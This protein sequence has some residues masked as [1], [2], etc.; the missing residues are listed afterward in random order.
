MSP[1][2]PT[3]VAP[4]P[5]RSRIAFPGC[6]LRRE[7]VWRWAILHPTGV[8]RLDEAARALGRSPGVI[9]VALRGLVAAGALTVS[10][11]TYVVR[12]RRI[13][14]I[15]WATFHRPQWVGALA[16]RLSPADI[17]GLMVPDATFTGASAVRLRLGQAPADASEVWV[18]A[19]PDTWRAIERRFADDRWPTA[20]RHLVNVRGLLPDPW[21][22]LDPLPWDQVW[23]DLWQC[24]AWWTVP[25]LTYLE[26][27]LRP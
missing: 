17:E 10:G 6:P 16:L 27:V 24:P 3:P 2:E 15:A 5:A 14:R 26:A 23:V 1:S 20:R 8:F 21:L 25:Y 11:A 19:T 9:R 12:N 4:R 7:W 22:P 18:Y 13:G